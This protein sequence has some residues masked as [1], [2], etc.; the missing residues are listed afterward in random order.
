MKKSFISGFSWPQTLL[1]QICQHSLGG[2]YRVRHDD[3]DVMNSLSNNI[4]YRGC[5]SESPSHRWINISARWSKYIL[6]GSKYSE[7]HGH[8]MM[9]FRQ[10]IDT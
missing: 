5:V 10:L 8:T 7:R 9:N 2:L 3:D 1:V 6:A 4:E